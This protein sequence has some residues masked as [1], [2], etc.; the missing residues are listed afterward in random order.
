MFTCRHRTLPPAWFLG[1]LRPLAR[2]PAATPQARHAGCGSMSSH[3]A[4]RGGGCRHAMG[5]CLQAAVAGPAGRPA[6]RTSSSPLRTL[7]NLAHGHGRPRPCLP[8][9]PRQARTNRHGYRPGATAQEH[10]RGGGW[11]VWHALHKG[12]RVCGAIGYQQMAEL[13]A[14]CAKR[15]LPLHVMGCEATAGWHPPALP[16]QCYV[17]VARTTA[18]PL[19]PALGL[20]SASQRVAAW[21]RRPSP[22]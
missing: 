10:E 21:A 12:Q 16:Q 14:N 19:L 17:P 8:S 22:D 2:K 15:P 7:R 4:R 6:P 5:P 13:H 9:P 3:L 18:L 11:R 1:V 20:C